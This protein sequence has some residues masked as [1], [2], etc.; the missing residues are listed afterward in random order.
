MDEVH[1]LAG[2]KRGDQLALG[3]A[4]LPTLAPAC[5]A[6]RAVGDGRASR[7]CDL[8]PMSAPSP[9]DRG[10]RTARR[11]SS[12]MMLPEGRAALVAAIWASTRAP[13]DHGAHPRAPA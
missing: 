8:S 9:A 13:G 1:A 12:P 5:A 2:T 10:S 6:G 3:L 4:R 11:R 7:R